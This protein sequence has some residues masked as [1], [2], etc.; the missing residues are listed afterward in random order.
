MKNYAVFLEGKDFELARKGTKEI[1]GF[2]VTV[3]VETASEG[4]ATA[5]AIE[6][7]KSYE[8]L[9]EAFSPSAA[10]TPRLNAKL[11]HEL[12]PNNKMK[13]TELVFFPMADEA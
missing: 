7:V 2:F 9:K 12:L 6:I 4:E 8:I 3:R 13:N 5:S 1:V 11:V 10:A